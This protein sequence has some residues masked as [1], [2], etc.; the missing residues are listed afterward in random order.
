MVTP[1][2]RAPPPLLA[3]NL[4]ATPLH[5][6]LCLMSGPMRLLDA[7]TYRGFPVGKWALAPSVCVGLGGYLTFGLSTIPTLI[8][9]SLA[10][11]GGLL[12]WVL[13]TRASVQ[14]GYYFDYPYFGSADLCDKVVLITGATPGGLGHEAAKS[15]ARMGANLVVT[16]RSEAKGAAAVAELGEKASFVVV[17]FLS[18]ASIRAGAATF[19]S[20]HSRLDVLVLNAGVG[21]TAEA[22]DCWMAN[23]IGPA[24]LVEQLRPLL[25]QTAL[26]GPEVGVRVVAVSS[27]SHFDGSIDYEQPYERQK[28]HPA[29]EVAYR[30][31]KLA[32]IMYMR[33]LQV[34]MRARAGLGG[35]SAIRCFAVSPG[36]AYTN[37]MA[38][39]PA[40]MQLLCRVLFRTP[41][42]GAQVIKMA[43]IDPHVPGGSYLCNCRV[44]RTSGA[45]DISNQPAEWD[46]LW[47]LTESCK[48]DSSKFP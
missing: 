13:R 44:E 33:A 21:G 34:R 5:S 20:R 37:I 1:L 2:P 40:E 18:A 31:S 3:L 23:H 22:A 46:K 38:G 41:Y 27:S 12:S 8:T 35:E 45:G 30:Q 42:M 32:Q 15:L 10:A 9:S 48:A 14:G 16:A 43:A 29:D 19:I 24:I 36:V 4:G 25:E 6:R 47:A 28:A 26:K 7:I 39:I 17:D 11:T